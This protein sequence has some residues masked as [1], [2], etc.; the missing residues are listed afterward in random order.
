MILDTLEHSSRYRTGLARLD[1]ALSFIG[2]GGLDALALGRHDLQGDAL[3]ALVQEYDTRPLASCRWEAHR[4]YIDVQLVLR[5]EERMGWAALGGMREVVPYDADRDV[6]FFEGA[7][8]F[9]TLRP[10]MFAVFFPQDA[11]MPQIALAA[12]V[13]VRKLVLKVAVS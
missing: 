10:G 1:A 11:H 9:F 4:R 5:G 2:R 6:A 8:E 7:G 12:P 13:A 3:Y